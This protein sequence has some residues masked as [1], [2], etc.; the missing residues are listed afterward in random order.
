MKYFLLLAKRYKKYQDEKKIF[1]NSTIK[2]FNFWDIE[3]YEEFWLQR[4]IVERGLN[5]NN[6][7]INF[8]SV[9]GPRNKLKLEKA[10]I[11][12][13][14]SGEAMSRFKKYDDFCLNEVDLAL[15]F[16]DINADNYLRFPL[17]IMDF[18]E[19]NAT[20]NSIEQK[21]NQLNYY[22]N[23]SVKI[24]EKFCSLIARHDENGLRK[25]IVTQLNQIE[26]VD[27]AGKLFNNTAS[28][29]TDF[30]DNKISFLENYK[31]NICPENTNQQNYTTEK[32]FESIAAGCI[33]IYWGSNQQPEPNV[34]NPQSVL[35]FDDANNNLQHQIN[36]IHQNDKLYLDFISQNPFQENAGKFIFETISKLESK[37]KEIIKN[38]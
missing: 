37:L 7:R 3:N 24:R 35:F 11:N 1:K 22:Q 19:P 4:F 20:L 2:F 8:F 34:I 26:T 5:P 23:N 30:N 25:K 31:F 15:G 21:I 29:K 14:F 10:T 13:F 9:F 28:L 16:D 18:F 12:I 27:C 36:E 33:P 38:A 17:W 6:K 32:L